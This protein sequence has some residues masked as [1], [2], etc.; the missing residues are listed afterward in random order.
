VE[1]IGES[2]INAMN[3]RYKMFVS[4]IFD[5]ALIAGSMVFLIYGKRR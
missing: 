1:R 2:G 5:R 3:P 4:M